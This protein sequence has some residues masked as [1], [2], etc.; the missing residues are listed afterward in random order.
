MSLD[1]LV[2]TNFK[3]FKEENDIFVS[4]RKLGD[5]HLSE[6]GDRL[7]QRKDQLMEAGSDQEEQSA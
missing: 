1:D 5:E 2:K 3:Y 6:L 7:Q 4:A